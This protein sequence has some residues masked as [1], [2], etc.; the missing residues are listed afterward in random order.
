MNRQTKYV[1]FVML[2]LLAPA[3]KLF[4]FGLTIPFYYASILG[5]RINIFVGDFKSS[6]AFC[7]SFVLYSFLKSIYSVFVVVSLV[8]SVLFSHLHK[9]AFTYYYL[10]FYPYSSCSSMP[11]ASYSPYTIKKSSFKAFSFLPYLAIT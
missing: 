10:S 11:L 3:Y 1:I 5:T 9:P 8:Q 7:M 4:L 6:D 2:V